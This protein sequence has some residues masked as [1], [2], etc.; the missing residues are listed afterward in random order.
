MMKLILLI[1]ILISTINSTYGQI[2]I[3]K[4]S[5]KYGSIVY[6]Y[7]ESNKKVREGLTSYGKIVY[8]KG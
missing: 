6:R 5:N 8:T 4:G 3:R 7:D 2:Y 1:I